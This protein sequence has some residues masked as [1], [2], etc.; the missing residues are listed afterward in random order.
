[1]L[2]SLRGKLIFI[3][4][5]LSVSVV[6]V[7]SGFARYKQKQFALD[8]A[9]ERAEVDLQL[10]DSDFR[11]VLDGVKRDLL[12]L[13]DLSGM[14]N[15]LNSE[16]EEQRRQG[17]L[18]FQAALLSLATYHNIFQQIQ[19]L[20]AAGLEVVRVNA[21][22][23]KAW[24][25]PEHLLRDRSSEPYFQQAIQLPP[26]RMY[27][28]PADRDQEH[29]TVEA[30]AVPIIRYAA[31]V[32]DGRGRKRGVLVLNVL[33]ETFFEILRSQQDKV[34]PGTLY[35]L[36]D[37]DGHFLFH[38]NDE[39][40]SGFKP[41]IHENFFNN[42]PGLRKLIQSQNQGAL[43]RTSEQTYRQT[44]FAFR[45]IHLA[46]PG[47]NDQR[48]YWIVMTTVNKA[49]LLVGMDEYIQAFVPFTLVLIILCIGAA[50]LVAWNCSRPVVSLAT[51][52]QRIQQGDLSARARVYTLD[53]MGKFGRQFNEMATKL[54]QTINRLQLS[55][56]KYRRIFENS[57]DCIF[58][59]DVHCNIIDINSAG[60]ALLGLEGE[61]NG[62][63]LPLNICRTEE[64]AGKPDQNK[65]TIMD[66]IRKN[67]YVKNYETLLR[68]PDGSTRQ[69]LLTA[70]S[71]FDDH[72]TLLGYEGIL[73]DITEEKQRQ[74][75]GRKFRKKLQ[76]EIVLAEE[77][78]RRNMGQILHEEMAQNLALVNLKLQEI[79]AGVRNFSEERQKEINT[80][81]EN[82]Q[83]LTKLMIRQIRTMIFDLYPVIL[84]DQGLVPAMIWYGDNFTRQTGIEVS[85]YGV[86]G[87]LGLSDSQKIYLFR[88]FKELIHNAWKHA[89]ATEIV[90][91]VKTKD[92]HVRLTI[93]D[94]GKGFSPEKIKHKTK[95]F[96]GIGL[97]SIR[98]WITAVN[99][100]MSI[101]SEPGKGTRIS[102]DI[103]LEEAEEKE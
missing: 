73:R 71:R 36:L 40:V 102:I 64:T 2:T 46:D 98:E 61:T 81:L 49:E 31:S 59:T 76:E 85:V 63:Q 39:N 11:S 7:S 96:K 69:C 103:P 92:N 70:S 23:T 47:F 48:T 30:P 80:E 8:R 60:R 6:I 21:T 66:D 12:T 62:N 32:V 74:R 18:E 17:L 90:A 93:D 29:G 84:D 91:T 97:V 15:M 44:L 50:V 75:A 33:G 19:F 99:G 42:E 22:D 5:L 1:M 89:D 13:R 72:G 56:S 94:A 28:S 77:R 95:K 100:T 35:F 51:A 34:G 25:T 78:E 52:A 38:R 43:I 9:K 101:E 16:T 24:P 58:V 10:L 65:T 54:E 68:R 53:D 45:K 3:F 4:V 37:Q 79:K 82:I 55:E 20:D 67:G 86:P 14:H 27:I 83:V 57:R 87:S 41:A 88:S 26:D